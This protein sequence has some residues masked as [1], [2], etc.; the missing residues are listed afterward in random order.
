MEEFYNS[1][2]KQQ[3]LHHEKN[4]FLFK[5]KNQIIILE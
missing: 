5:L 4:R 2:G 1:K 3:E